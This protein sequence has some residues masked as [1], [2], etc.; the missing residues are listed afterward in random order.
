MSYNLTVEYVDLP[1]GFDPDMCTF[2]GSVVVLSDGSDTKKY[3]YSD[4]WWINQEVGEVTTLDYDGMHDV[5]GFGK[6]NGH[7]TMADVSV[8]ET[9][10]LNYALPNPDAVTAFSDYFAYVAHGKTVSK[11]TPLDYGGRFERPDRIVEQSVTVPA[12]EPVTFM[13]KH[14]RGVICVAG[15]QIYHYSTDLNQLHIYIWSMG[16]KT[17]LCAKLIGEKLFV[18][19]KTTILSGQIDPDSYHFL[20]VVIRD[21]PDS[22]KA[23]S[24][25][26]FGNYIA[27]LSIDGNLTIRDTTTSV[28]DGVPEIVY[29]INSAADVGILCGDNNIFVLVTG[30]QLCFFSF[31]EEQEESSGS[32]SDEEHA[33][34]GGPAVGSK[35][36]EIMPEREEGETDV[37]Y[38]VKRMAFVRQALQHLTPEERIVLLTADPAELKDLYEETCIVCQDP[39]HKRKDDDGSEVPRKKPITSKCEHTICEDCETQMKETAQRNHEE[40]PDLYPHEEPECPTCRT[41][42]ERSSMQLLL[43]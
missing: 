1:E 24:A 25:C 22:E 3:S 39:L 18:V 21:F 16:S 11:L 2:T 38:K 15:G 23:T 12:D 6:A 17:A 19:Y 27:I 37:R 4:K 31:I 10:L 43:F 26:V 29:R 20:D 8:V 5:V 28:Y 14:E 13:L 35:R 32:S 30:D 42:W 34:G 41:P 33:A 36:R 40:D 9:D 7:V